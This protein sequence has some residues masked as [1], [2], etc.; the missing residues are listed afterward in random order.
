[1]L[2]PVPGRTGGTGKGPNREKNGVEEK[3]EMEQPLH[4]SS[5]VEAIQ[6]SLTL[7]SEEAGRFVSK[8]LRCRA[9]VKCRIFR[10]RVA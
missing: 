5:P 10:N 9:A 1:L 7:Y 6:T 3:G 4:G 2:E 8:F